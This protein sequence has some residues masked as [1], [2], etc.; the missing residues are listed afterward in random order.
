MQQEQKVPAQ[1]WITTFSGTAINLCLGI[2]YAWSLWKA[3]LV[4]VEK[5]G[6]PFPADSLNA[7][8]TYLTNAEA[9]TP[10]TLCVIIFNLKL[11]RW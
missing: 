8:W 3:A 4:N 1:A 9:A 2:L 5:A 10:Y 11:I 7:G 6:Q